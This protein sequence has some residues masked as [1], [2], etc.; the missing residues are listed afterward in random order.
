MAKTVIREEEPAEESLRPGLT[1]KA[2]KL[3][4]KVRKEIET[5][6]HQTDFG[7]VRLA[8]LLAQVY[9]NGWVSA[10]GFE[11][12][13]AYGST[14]NC[15]KSK[16]YALVR[17][18]STIAAITTVPREQLLALGWS[19][20]RELARIIDEENAPELTMQA[21]Q[22]SHR[23][24]TRLVRAQSETS[25]DTGLVTL[26]FRITPG[27]AAP[28]NDALSLASEMFK[29]EDAGKALGN[30]CLGWLE[31]EHGGV[32]RAPLERVLAWVQLT[33]GIEVTATQ[34]GEVIYGRR[35]SAL[36]E[37]MEVTDDEVD[38][39]LAGPVEEVSSP[40]KPGRPKKDKKEK[41]KKNKKERAASLDDV[42]A[43]DDTE[44]GEPL[45]DLD[46]EADLVSIDKLLG[47]KV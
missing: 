22:L 3:A 36:D 41:G 32:S 39:E 9:E 20:L 10:W 23:E 34:D 25:R 28:V 35:D 11:D 33:F 38:E 40:K 24:L 46:D 4:E 5:L 17:I 7:F 18:W 29:T 21:T 14:L 2:A 1:G 43:S 19:K 31:S 45:D 44:E 27:D 12:F 42:L 26:T 16:A 15:G 30:I 8:E 47:R 13:G 6:D 37:A